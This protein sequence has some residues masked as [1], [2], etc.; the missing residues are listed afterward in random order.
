MCYASRPNSLII[1]ANGTLGKCTVALSDERNT[2][3]RLLPSG[4]LQI[5]QSKL[6]WWIRGLETGRPD[7]LECPKQSSDLVSIQGRQVVIIHNEARL[8]R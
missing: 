8:G 1:R 6:R 7:E 4:D 2:V 3:G 5:D